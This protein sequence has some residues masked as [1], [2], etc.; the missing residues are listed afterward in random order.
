MVEMR[1]VRHESGE[2]NQEPASGVMRKRA[3]GE[4]KSECITSNDEHCP[5]EGR[6]CR[7]ENMRGCCV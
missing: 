5:I 6:K 3:R 2:V 4:V 1:R 7:N